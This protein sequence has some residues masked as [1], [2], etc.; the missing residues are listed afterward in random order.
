MAGIEAGGHS[1]SQRETLNR[2][3]REDA[4]ANSGADDKTPPFG[5]GALIRVDVVPLGASKGG[6]P[7]CPAGTSWDGKQCAAVVN[8]TCPEGFEFKE[9]SGCAP[10]APQRAA[11]TTCPMGDAAKCRERCSAG[12][13]ASCATFG[14]ML[15]KGT[16]VAKD[17]ALAL[18]SFSRACDG[19]ELKACV[20]AG[21]L[22]WQLGRGVARDPTKG[23]QL[24]RKACDG[25]EPTGCADMGVA[26]RQG[27]GVARDDTEAAKYFGLACTDASSVGCV[28]L[29]L[30]YRDGQGVPRDKNKV[31]ALLGQACNGGV[32][33]GCKLRSDLG[34]QP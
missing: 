32:P 30:L 2:D 16:G 12:H 11:N 31:S 20:Q 25:G 9:G 13:A 7:E 23:V 34:L 6:P 4:C 17:P 15:L 28:G 18:A 5:C 14:A 1:Q 3:G 22:L 33:I 21:E 29:A 10:S 24:F 27:D 26:L 19:G 8:K